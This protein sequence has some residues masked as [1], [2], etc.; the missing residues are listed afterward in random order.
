MNVRIKLPFPLFVE[1]FVLGHNLLLD[2]QGLIHQFVHILF[3]IDLTQH[4]C[5]YPIHRYQKATHI[6]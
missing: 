1:D 6:E 2:I 4:F 3:G 5:H